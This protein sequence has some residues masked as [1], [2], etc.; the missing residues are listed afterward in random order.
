MTLRI[1]HLTASLFLVE[2]LVIIASVAPLLLGTIIGAES[3]LL[4][5]DK[6]SLSPS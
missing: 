4:R 6:I 2:P 1:I 5:R 3:H